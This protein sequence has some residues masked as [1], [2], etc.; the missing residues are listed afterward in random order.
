MGRQDLERGVRTLSEAKTS[1]RGTWSFSEAETHPRN[2]AAARLEEYRSSPFG[3]PLW[4]S[5]P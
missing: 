2:T 5:G 4:L 1:W 3:G